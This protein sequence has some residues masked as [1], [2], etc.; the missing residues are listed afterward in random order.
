LTGKVKYSVF[1]DIGYFIGVEFDPGSL[2][3]EHRYKPQ[4][5]LDPR[6]LS[7]RGDEGDTPAGPSPVVN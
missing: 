7:G 4:H 1:R 3:T 6:R 5:L 2:W